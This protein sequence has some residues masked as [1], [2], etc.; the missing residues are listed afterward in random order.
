MRKIVC[1]SIVARG[2]G[3]YEV[4]LMDSAGKGGVFELAV[5]AR[6]EFITWSED[7]VDYL[8]HLDMVP[9][10]DLFRAVWAFHVGREFDA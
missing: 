8:G 1:N 3:R 7:F 4:A 10:R 9:A 5:G 6:H 2:E